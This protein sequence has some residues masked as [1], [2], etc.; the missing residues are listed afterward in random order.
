MLKNKKPV[1]AHRFAYALLRGPI[2]KDLELCHTCDVPACVRPEHLFP[3]SRLDNV[4]DMVAK[5][6]VPRGDEHWTR[7]HPEWIKRKPG[8]CH[9]DVLAELADG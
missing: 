1:L 8:P 4:R 3:G 2:P 9:G 6:R 7:R 5:R